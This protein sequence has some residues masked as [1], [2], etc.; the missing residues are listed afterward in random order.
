M[1]QPVFLIFA[2]IALA[3][4]SLLYCQQYDPS[5]IDK[6]AVALL[7]DGQYKAEEGQDVQAIT[8]ATKAL[9]KD[10]RYLDAWLL[11]AAIHSNNK[12]HRESVSAYEKAF[13]IDSMYSFEYKLP[14]SINLAGMGEFEKSPP[15]N[16]PA[17]FSRTFKSKYKKGW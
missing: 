15:N 8:L 4:P 2:V 7:N 10:S 12:R 16:Q 5:K 3:F 11:I 17:A 1:K 13:S 9:E 14:Y 6:K